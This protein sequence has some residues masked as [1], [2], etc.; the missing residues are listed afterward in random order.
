[1]KIIDV[2]CAEGKTGFYFDDQKAIKMGAGHDGFFYTGKPVTEGFTSI[3]QAGEAISVMF[4]LEDRSHTETVLPYSIPEQA[5]AI[6][7]FW[8]RTL[9][10]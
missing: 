3:R 1:M 5:D 9:F 7:S 6:P 2:V 4:I 10:P 8:Q